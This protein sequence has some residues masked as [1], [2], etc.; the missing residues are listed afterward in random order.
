MS[1]PQK[2]EL[3]NNDVHQ[4]TVILSLKSARSV[5]TV[6]GL[7]RSHIYNWCE[8]ANNVSQPAKHHKRSKHS[9]ELAN[10]LKNADQEY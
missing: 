8:G 2:T 1:E 5:D 9:P 6:F 4:F 7:H 3:G 10:A